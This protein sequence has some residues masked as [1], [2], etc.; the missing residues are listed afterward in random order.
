MGIGLNI[1]LG[2]LE[3][4]HRD[5]FSQSRYKHKQI[6]IKKCMYLIL[7]FRTVL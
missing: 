6:Q 1:R 2:Y 5:K 7:E 3:N 4:I